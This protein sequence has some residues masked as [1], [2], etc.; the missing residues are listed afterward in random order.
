MAGKKDRRGLVLV[1]T[2]NG[3]GKT[4]AA[5][6]LAFRALGYD[7]KVLMVQFLKGAWKPGEYRA[8]RKF[9]PNFQIAPMGQGFLWIDAENQEDRNRLLVRKAW[10][11]GREQVSSGDWDMVI[12]DEINYAIG[13]GLIPVPE[14][15]EMIRTKPPLLHVVLTGRNAKDEIVELADTVTEMRPVKHAYERGT[16]AQKGIE[17]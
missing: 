6:G 10:D 15:V 17:F 4:T 7:M 5:L 2:G 16:A 14:V 9:E 11:Y 8:A 3:K 13:Y 12:F 1:H